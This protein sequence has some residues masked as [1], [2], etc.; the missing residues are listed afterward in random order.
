MASD[1]EWISLRRTNRL[2]G[3]EAGE[4]LGDFII[5]ILSRNSRRFGR[6]KSR[7]R[8]ARERPSDVFASTATARA[9]G[10]LGGHGHRAINAGQSA[11]GVR[12]QANVRRRGR[13]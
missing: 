2:L 10:L 7:S 3:N 5:P 13:G 11:V 4:D 9:F 8:T 1:H 12:G 6:M